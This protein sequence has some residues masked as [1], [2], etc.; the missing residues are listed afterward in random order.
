MNISFHD[1]SP[2]K[3]IVENYQAISE[4]V[5]GF[6]AI[7]RKSVLTVGSWDLL[8][9]GHV[10]YLNR[11]RSQG[12]LLVVGI[13]T[14]RAIKKY[15]GLLRP[16]VPYDER[17]EM[18]SYQSCVDFVTPIDD[19]DEKGEWQYNLVKTVRPDIF[20]AVE[21]SYPQ[22]QLDEIQRHCGSLIV[23]PRQAKDTSTSRLIQN[24]VK[25]HLDQVYSLME[26]KQ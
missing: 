20:V 7:G 6:R 19:V 10:R 14:D 18:L 8:H 15:K 22:T 16:I 2:Y 21:D 13:D 11:A 24:A 9:I 3:K 23:F 5:N 26:R 1:Y 17:C 4:V 12:D 25:Q